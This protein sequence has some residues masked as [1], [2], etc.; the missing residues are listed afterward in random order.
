[1]DSPRHRALALE[2]AEQAITLLRNE[3]DLLP[4]AKEQKLAFI[5]Y[6][7]NSTQDLLSSYNGA[8]TLVNSHSAL[9]AAQNLGLDVTFA[10][11]TSEHINDANQSF[12]PAAVAAAR[13][14][15]IAVVFV[16][17]SALGKADE[18]EEHDR[19]SL[20]L[21]GAQEPLLDAV[22]AAQPRTV[23]V[24]VGGG[25]LSV[26]SARNCASCAVLYAF[27]PGELGGDAIV[28][29]II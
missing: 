29:H 25:S 6:H 1:M 21:P 23:I 10:R 18:G 7:A 5:G 14:A 8:N 26:A 11:G 12:V 19:S 4:L 17:I 2:A 28:R 22:L 24:L 16:G 9:L 27:Y 15:D 20:T 13:A 3:G